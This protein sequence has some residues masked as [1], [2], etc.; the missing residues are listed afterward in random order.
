MILYRCLQLFSLWNFYEAYP[1]RSNLF[2]KIWLLMKWEDPSCITTCI[3][4]CWM[5]ACTLKVIMWC[6]TGLCEILLRRIGRCMVQQLW[7]D[8]RAIIIF[9]KHEVN[10]FASCTLWQL[11]IAAPFWYFF[12]SCLLHGMVRAY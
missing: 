1:P 11:L 3:F 4:V 12:C 6:V 8:V 7:W 10:L 2:F 9:V 5:K